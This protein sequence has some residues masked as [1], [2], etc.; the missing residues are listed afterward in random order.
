MTFMRLLISLFFAL[1]LSAADIAAILRDRVEVRKA[2][3]AIV[4]AVV[5]PEGSTFYHHGPATEDSLFRVASATKVFT[6]L[7]L[8]GMVERG[9]MALDDPVAKY[10]PDGVVIPAGRRAIT[11]RDLATHRSGLPSMPSDFR[12]DREYGQRE[13]YAYLAKCRLQSEPGAQF[14]YSNLGMALLGVALSRR[15]NLTY[16]QLL[17]Q[18]VTT[19]LG[20]KSSRIA[21]DPKDPRLAPGHDVRLRPARFHPSIETLAGASE[22]VSSARDLAAFLRAALGDSPLQAALQ[23]S[24]TPLTTRDEYHA[25]IGYGWWLDHRRSRTFIWHGGESRDGYK[26]F[27]GLDP[28]RKIG[29]VVLANSRNGIEDIGMHI[30]DERMKLDPF[31]KPEPRIAVTAPGEYAGRYQVRPDYAVTIEVKGTT[32]F[33]SGGHHPRRLIPIERDSFVVDG[34]PLQ[35]DFVRSE[36]GKLTSL[37]LHGPGQVAE[38]A[39]P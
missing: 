30:L 21:V 7:L 31:G 36:E 8:A 4:V 27:I 35:I 23:R 3:P 16:E 6:G 10:L 2:A 19:P 17:A 12:D 15:A 24:M 13:L 33:G 37:I 29:V 14:R 20:M 18:R 11:L 39:A 32:L 38:G 25:E 5:T 22:L 1:H 28:E 34:M 9:E 26:S